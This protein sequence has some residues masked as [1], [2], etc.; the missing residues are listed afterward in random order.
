MPNSLKHP[1]EIEIFRAGQHLDSNGREFTWSQKDLDSIAEA[2][3]LQTYRP[4]LI[5]SPTLNHQTQ[6]TDDE[7]HQKPYCHGV[8]SKL[9]RKGNRLIAQFNQT[10]KE[11][12]SWLK[13]K[14]IPG[15][16]ASFYL[17]DSPSNPFPG[18]KALRHIAA[19]AFPAVKGMALPAG[20]SEDSISTPAIDDFVAFFEV[21][22][23]QPPEFQDSATA[24]YKSLFRSLRE[25]LIESESLDR[26]NRLLPAEVIE[27]LPPILSPNRIQEM[28]VGIVSAKLEEMWGG[29]EGSEFGESLGAFLQLKRNQRRMTVR[30]LS[31]AAQVPLSTLEKILSGETGLPQKST[32]EKIAAALNLVPESLAAISTL[33]SIDL[34]E[35]MQQNEEQQ[36]LAQREQLE[37]LKALQESLDLLKRENQE[38]KQQA[39][40]AFCE[41]LNLPA[42]VKDDRL[43]SF[44][45]TLNPEQ[46]AFF[47]AWANRVSQEVST[48]PSDALFK[49]YAAASEDFS[50]TRE[51]D[52]IETARQN[53]R[54]SYYRQNQY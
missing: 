10:S 19:V 30:E 25:H 15:F 23:K 5:A 44:T 22:P 2:F 39:V 32:L 40:A 47:A 12:K 36:N 50:E 20:F 29:S 41:N 9:V 52:P 26:A 53:V 24:G 54:E 11:F 38:L 4:P 8:P 3:D 37:Q 1:I 21:T 13:E 7:Q 31:E 48:P 42:E 34:E 14:R 17:E 49:E 51:E 45:N 46:F 33:D 16:S 27:S 43:R 6:G 35:I 28:V 18:R